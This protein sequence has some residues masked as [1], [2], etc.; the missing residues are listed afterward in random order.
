MQ[1]VAGQGGAPRR[2]HPWFGRG[3]LLRKWN[4]LTLIVIED[5]MKRRRLVTGPGQHHVPISRDRDVASGLVSFSLPNRG[6][7]PVAKAG[8][9]DCAG[10]GAWGLI[11]HHWVQDPPSGLVGREVRRF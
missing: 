2:I 9:E 6:P 8:D 10:V 4:V 3:K 5:Q 7:G 11:T 1:S